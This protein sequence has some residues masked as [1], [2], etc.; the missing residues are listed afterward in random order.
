MTGG[1]AVIDLS[2]W[3]LAGAVPLVGVI[4]AVSISPA[5]PPVAT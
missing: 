1:A 5:W 2:V 3:Q 4:A